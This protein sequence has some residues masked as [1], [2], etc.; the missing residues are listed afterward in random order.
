MRGRF[1]DSKGSCALSC[2]LQDEQGCYV[3][4]VNCGF[5]S[6]NS[7]RYGQIGSKAPETAME[8]V[9]MRFD[10]E[11]IEDEF[12]DDAPQL[13]AYP[14]GS[15]RREEKSTAPRRI[16]TAAPSVPKL[17]A[18]PGGGGAADDDSVDLL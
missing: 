14:G 5:D 9:G 18:P 15:D 2:Q 17:H 1:R 3:C 16:D 8:S 11:F 4:L 7:V 13:M 6:F 10:A 12:A